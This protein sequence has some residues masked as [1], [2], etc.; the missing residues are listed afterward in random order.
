[1]RQRWKKRKLTYLC[2]EKQRRDEG[3]RVV[4]FFLRFCSLHPLFPILFSPAFSLF[5]IFFSPVLEMAKT[6]ANLFF[7]CLI[8]GDE[9]WFSSLPCCFFSVTSLL[10]LSLFFFCFFFVSVC[11]SLS[12]LPVHSP[13]FSPV[14][15]TVFPFLPFL[16]FSSP[17]SPLGS[18]V[19]P[20]VRGSFLSLPSLGSFL[21]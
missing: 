13:R 5:C 7:F 12:L 11:F 2:A 3:F 4:A 16:A 18:L 10:S 15:S 21:F 6:V 8:S 1:M 19:L 9:N 14:F 20:P 17:L